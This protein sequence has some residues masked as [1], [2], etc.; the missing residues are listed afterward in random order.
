MDT[1]VVIF[2]SP[3]GGGK[4]TQADELVRRLGFVHL[5]TS[6]IIEDKFKTSDPND[7]VIKRQKELW[8]SGKLMDSDVIMAW[9]INRIRELAEQKQ[10]ISFSGSPRTMSEAETELPLLAQLYGMQ[11]IYIFHVYVS[12]ETSIERNSQ[13]RIC[14]AQ[15]HPVPSTLEHKDVTVC[16]WDGSALVR[17]ALDTAEVIQERYHVYEKETEPIV[18]FARHH[19]YHVVDLYGERPISEVT[20]DILHVLDGTYKKPS[21]D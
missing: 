10:S 1:R 6:K 21:G 12:E 7:P 16:P 8:A 11:N 5:E 9:I 20:Q 13:R 18:E 15:R 17:R 2:V 14:E 3:P 19:G 4:G